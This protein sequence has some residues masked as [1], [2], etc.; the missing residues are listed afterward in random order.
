MKSILKVPGNNRLCAAL[1][2]KSF[3]FVKYPSPKLLILREMGDFLK[4]VID[5]L[6][7]F[8]RGRA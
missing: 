7:E 4:R 3:N 6:D 8:F 2:K 5:E 1:G